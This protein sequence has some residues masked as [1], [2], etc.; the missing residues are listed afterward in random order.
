MYLDPDAGLPSIT[1]RYMVNGA[2]RAYTTNSDPLGINTNFSET[3]M[4]TLNAGDKVKIRV[5][6]GYEE[7]AEFL[8]LSPQTQD[9]TIE[10]L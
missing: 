3:V 10:R 9:L 5:S 4:L 6:N 1:F 2:S 7:P 8:N